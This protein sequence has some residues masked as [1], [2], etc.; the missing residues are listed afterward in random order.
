[1]RPLENVIW[2]ALT[3]R[4]TR[5][6]QSFGTARRFVPEV[7]PLAAFE[8]HGDEGYVS[9]AGLVDGGTVGVFLEEPYAPRPGWEFVVGA[10]LLQMICENGAASA[11]PSNGH[12]KIEVLGDK[13]SPEMLE[14]TALTK[15][16]PFSTRTH[17]LGY[18]VGIRDAGKL[19]A[20]AGERLK[21]PGH[22][23]VSAV[24]THPDH[25]G[26]GYAA[27]LMNEVMSA[28]RGRGETAFLHVRGDNPRAIALYERLGFRISWR[29]H[30]A[31]LRK[32]NRDA[33]ASQVSHY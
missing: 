31:V 6:A 2:Q 18:Y 28:I 5:F 24:C 15:P 23:E 9:L 7:G 25:L 14:L 16:G 32:R 11:R 17:E 22:T 13:D 27:T 29:G 12:P 8:Q 20:M 3:T 4:H 26:K 21:V 19:V 33:E 10:P 1:M 30:F